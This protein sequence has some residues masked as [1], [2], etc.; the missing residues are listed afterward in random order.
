[1][2]ELDRGRPKKT[3]WDR[4]K[5]DMESLGLSQKDAQSRNKWRIKGATGL[6]R[7]AYFKGQVNAILSG[8]TFAAKE[9]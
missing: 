7:F 9:Q 3:W 1:L 8:S 5:N 2:K 6:P 4:V